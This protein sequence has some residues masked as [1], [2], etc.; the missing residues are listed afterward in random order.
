MP[1]PQHIYIYIY[2]MQDV[3]LEIRSSVAKSC[4][5]NA[6]RFLALLGVVF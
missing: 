6:I 3:S 4:H 1:S 2:S 5:G